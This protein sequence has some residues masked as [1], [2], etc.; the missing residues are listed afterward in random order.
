[1]QDGATLHLPSSSQIKNIL[2]L[3]THTMDF[4]AWPSGVKGCWSLQQLLSILHTSESIMP[5]AEHQ[6]PHHPSWSQEGKKPQDIQNMHRWFQ[7][8][9]VNTRNCG[10]LK[11]EEIWRRSNSKPIA[12][13]STRKQKKAK[14]QLFWEVGSIRFPL[15][16]NHNPSI[17]SQR[18][19]LR[20]L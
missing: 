17:G 10:S 9:I 14:N 11:K 4:G 7:A 5:N 20:L 19:W 3:C 1:M 8:C 13:D 6:F 12:L 18:K 16:P 2:F 15:F